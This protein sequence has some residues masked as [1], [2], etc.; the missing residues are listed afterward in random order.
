VPSEEIEKIIK[1]PLSIKPTIYLAYAF[2]EKL[3]IPFNPKYSLYWKLISRED[4][5]KFLDWIFHGRIVRENNKIAR[6]VLL[7]REEK[8]VLERL[9]L[10]HDVLNKEY[11]IIPKEFAYLFVRMFGIGKR[12]IRDILEIMNKHQEDDVLQLMNK[13]CNIKQRDKAGIFIG[14]RMGRPEKAKMRKM[15]GSPQVLFPVG[16]QGGKYRSFQAALQEGKIEADFPVYECPSCSKNTPLSVCE[17]CN[18]PAKRKFFCNTC[19]EID[20]EECPNNKEHNVLAYKNWSIDIRNIFSKSLKRLDTR[21]YPDLIKGVRGTSSRDHSTE[22]IIKGILRAR[23]GI[24]VNKDGTIRYDSSEVPITH[25]KPREVGASVEK[26]K[27]L[28]LKCVIG[29]SELSYLIV[30]SLLT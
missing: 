12:T 17:D 3:D 7:N 19:G 28:G 9:G 8:D 13:I 11:I 2:S 5:I 10:E 24:Y 4:F 16:N 15:T 30:P 18:I 1:N 6:M 20:S 22:H 21:I 23:H 29:T 26:L 25:F 27:K 14:A